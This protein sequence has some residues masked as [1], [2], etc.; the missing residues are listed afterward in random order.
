MLAANAGTARERDMASAI[1]RQR[2]VFTI[3]FMTGVAPF[4]FS[5][6]LVGIAAGDSLLTARASPPFSRLPVIRGRFPW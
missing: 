1:I 5:L 4:V 3:F 6:V 2:R